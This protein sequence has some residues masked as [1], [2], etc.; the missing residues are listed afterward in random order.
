MKIL[1]YLIFISIF[2]GIFLVIY[3]QSDEKGFRRQWIS[4]K[5]AVLIQAS[6]AGLISESAEAKEFNGFEST[7]Q[8]VILVR[9]NSGGTSSNIPS[10]IG[11][12]EQSPSNFPTPLSRGRSSRPVYVPKHRTA[13]KVV[14]A[15]LGAAA[16]PAGAG[17]RVGNT[18][19][20]D[21]CPVQK[22]QQSQE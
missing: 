1:R 2:S 8:K 22:N 12:Q 16:N 6:A 14:D 3:R 20:D 19:F 17:D 7:D 10:N 21:Q 15:G 9:N 11:G 18:E 13:P 5:I 4:F